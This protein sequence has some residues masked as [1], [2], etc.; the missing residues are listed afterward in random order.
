MGQSR[1][2]EQFVGREMQSIIWEEV[3]GLFWPE[4]KRGFRR[5]RPCIP[6]LEEIAALIGIEWLGA[7][8]VE[9]EPIEARDGA[10]H[11]GVTSVATGKREGG[12]EARPIGRGADG[13]RHPGG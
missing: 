2:I 9:D 1:Q 8:I 13:L 12:E 3:R 4:Q 10:Q 7:P 5:S 11:S 6:I